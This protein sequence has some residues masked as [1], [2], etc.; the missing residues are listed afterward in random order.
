M[1]GGAS[2]IVLAGPALLACAAVAP[3]PERP[4]V[5]API[6]A[7]E[8]VT[9]EAG[10]QGVAPSGGVVGT[11]AG[12][13]WVELQDAKGEVLGR[14]QAQRGSWSFSEVSRPI[15]VLRYGCD[16]DGDGIVL[17]A[18]VTMLDAARLPERGTI[19]VLMS[20]LDGG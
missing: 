1:P 14:V 2:L 7:R 10:A 6:D 3:A 19:L 13:T 11:C 4:R 20:S 9:P 5:Q 12:A 8:A 17:A 16:P 15:T 18:D